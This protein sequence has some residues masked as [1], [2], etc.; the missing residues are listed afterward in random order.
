[1]VLAGGLGRQFCFLLSKNFTCYFFGK[2]NMLLLWKKSKLFLCSQGERKIVSANLVFRW[3]HVKCFL[4][5]LY[6]I[7][8]IP[9]EDIEFAKVRPWECLNLVLTLSKHGQ[10][11]HSFIHSFFLRVEELFPVIFLSWIFIRIWT[12][13]PKFLPWMSGLFISVM[14]VQSYFIGNIHNVLVISRDTTFLL[15]ILFFINSFMIV[16]I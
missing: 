5:Q 6:E 1:M 11:W 7:S 2:S 12:G 13:I 16:T 9:V 4:L 15:Y 3:A 14:M 8:G 10:R